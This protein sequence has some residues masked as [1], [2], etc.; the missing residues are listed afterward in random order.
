MTQ[1]R[2]ALRRAILARGKTQPLADIV[3]AASGLRIQDIW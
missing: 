3:Y 1:I 2:S